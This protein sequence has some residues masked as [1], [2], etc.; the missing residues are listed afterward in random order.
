MIDTLVIYCA[1]DKELVPM[2]TLSPKEIF[3]GCH[4]NQTY[5]FKVTSPS[6]NLYVDDAPLVM[7]AKRAHW[8]WTPGF[9][10]GQVQLELTHPER[11]S[12]ARY[13]IDVAPALHK[14]G[15]EQFLEYLNEIVSFAP[16]LLAGTEPARHGLGGRSA[17]KFDLWIRYARLRSFI[18]RYIV[19]LNAIL[20][21]PIS[22]IRHYRNQVPV[23]SAQRLDST[24]LLRLIN[25]PTLLVAL[26][27]INTGQADFAPNSTDLDVPF[28]EHTL[29]N[30]AN[31]LIVRQLESVRRHV[32]ELISGFS[33]LSLKNTSPTETETDIALRLPRRLDYLAEIRSKLLKTSRSSVFMNVD[34]SRH[35][36]TEFNSVTGIPHYNMTHQ[37]G[38]R[39]LRRGFSTLKDD[40]L[41]Y[42]APTW[43]IY[44]A[45]CFVAIAQ[46]LQK[47]LPQFYWHLNDSPRH[48]D[49]LLSGKNGDQTISL[50]FQMVCKSQEDKNCYGYYS[51]SRE[52]RPDLILEHRIKDNVDYVCLDSKYTSSSQRILES[53][54][55]AHIYRDSIKLSSAPPKLS[56]LLVPA[57]L[58]AQRLESQDY[59]DT[60]GTGCISAG[61]TAQVMELIPKLLR[62]LNL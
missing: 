19:G 17:S 57:N 20:D 49:L 23:R 41:L 59:L 30:P 31:R 43:G 15:R 16:Q 22:R 14:T 54:A 5:M 25:N 36:V 37:I 27:H 45:W 61:N 11:R 52:R 32:D 33:E 10:A 48:A 38:V 62:T 21:R 40:E 35:G 12:V 4:E 3:V 7:D 26:S 47:D 6:A 2:G 9:Y 53:M 51:I 44:E 42:L 24:S 56:A 13:L 1:T 18:D 58:G 39:L 50:Y 55:S 46:G 29:D 28:N 60:Y 34:T 8:L